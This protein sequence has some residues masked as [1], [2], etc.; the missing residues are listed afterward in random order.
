MGVRCLGELTEPRLE[1][2]RKADKIVTDEVRAAGLENEIW[3]S[4]AVLLP[5]QSV[6]VMGDGRTYEETIAIR[7]VTSRD[8]M[9]ADW[10][11][12]PE[13]LLRKMSSRIVNETPGVNRVV[14]D[15]STKP[16]ST[17]EWE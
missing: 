11:Y 6:G 13:P 7:A 14:L 3:Q 1:K 5:V 12:F 2:L 17:I 16:P 10:V 15:I 4:F 8:G 9:T